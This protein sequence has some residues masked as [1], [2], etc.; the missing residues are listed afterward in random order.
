MAKRKG[1][2]L[3]QLTFSLGLAIIFLSLASFYYQYVVQRHILTTNIREELISQ[4]TLVRAWLVRAK[5]DQEREQIAKQYVETLEHIDQLKQQVLIIRADGTVITSS[6][7]YFSA[8]MQRNAVKPGVA[9]EGVGRVEGEYYVVALPVFSDPALKTPAAAILIRQPMTVVGR[10][11]D[12]LMLGAFILLAVTLV[13][14]VSVVYYVVR[15]KVHKPM[16]AIFM[17]E[18]R[19]REGDL[20]RIEAEDPSN[21]FS[22]L[23]AMYNEMVVRIA[24]QKKATL[25]QKDDVSVARAMRQAVG[26]LAQPLEDIGTQC[27]TLLEHESSL[28]PA[29][30]DALK[31]I[32]ADVTRIVREL[33]V[34]VS[35][36]NK[37]ASLLKRQAERIRKYDQD[38][39]KV[40]GKYVL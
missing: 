28:D 38:G 25:S 35:E 20:A 33:N 5:T 37:S 8:D 23:Y 2:L 4:A 29:D 17:Q 6:N 18:Y 12:S 24:E 31:K 14:I 3:R 7:G 27:R 26:K 36:G 19:I 16:Q 21:E 13:I 39:D 9:I 11:I 30:R 1:S 15:L 10:L 34:L 40:K 22:D 32:V